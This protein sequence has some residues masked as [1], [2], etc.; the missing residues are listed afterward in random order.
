MLGT[1]RISSCRDR[2]EARVPVGRSDQCRAFACGLGSQA[3]RGSRFPRPPCDPGQRVFPSPVL[4]LAILPL[5]AHGVRNAPADSEH[6][7]HSRGL[8]A[9]LV[10]V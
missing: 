3:D 5:P 6:A 4:T 10:P 8:P 7:P 2:S 1:L 9:K